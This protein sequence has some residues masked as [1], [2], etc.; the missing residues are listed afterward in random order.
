[1]SEET[2]EA[3]NNRLE[4]YEIALQPLALY[5]HLSQFLPICVVITVLAFFIMLSG[6]P[7]WAIVIFLILYV[8]FCKI[9][10]DVAEKRANSQK[11]SRDGNTLSARGSYCG[12]FSQNT[13]SLDQ[14]S[15]ITL[16]QTPLMRF[17]KIWTIE[18]AV[19]G[20][21]LSRIRFYG[22]KRAIEVQKSLVNARAEVMNSKSKF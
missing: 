13:F 8:L 16:V 3:E 2:S 9:S 11:Y 12:F 1:M 14:V 10:S 19:S 20:G 15:R 5:F 21:Q 18:F 6:A 7:L 4:H 17:C 22:L